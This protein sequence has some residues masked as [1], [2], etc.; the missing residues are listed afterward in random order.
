MS[1]PI[2][3]LNGDDR[4][5]ALRTLKKAIK[6]ASGAERKHLLSVL[7]SLNP[8]AARSRASKGASS[9]AKSTKKAAHHMGHKK[10][11]VSKHNPTT[12]HAVA[13]KVK[14]RV[15]AASRRA[16]SNFKGL[17]LMGIAKEG[18]GVGLGLVG[19]NILTKQ[20]DKFLPASFP[21]IVKSALAAG[22]VGGAA[23][24]FGGSR[25]FTRYVAVG[26]IGELIQSAARIYL[27][28]GLMSGTD[29]TDTSTGYWDPQT[30]QWIPYGGQS[31]AGVIYD[32][33]YPIPVSDDR[34][35]GI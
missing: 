3:I 25:G 34:P 11:P 27:P 18:L 32:P 8:N 21:A 19:T 1:E 13:A 29:T 5:Y 10:H 20:A 30:G 28:G 7:Q 24:A 16:V 4:P 31:L 17:D 9:M 33:G 26:A 2:E 14:Q 35:A 12:V 6:G 15:G 22:V 23:V